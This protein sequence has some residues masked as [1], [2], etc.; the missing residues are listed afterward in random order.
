MGA[1]R[2]AARGSNR[3]ALGANGLWLM[4]I[5]LSPFADS[6]RDVP[7]FRATNPDF[8]TMAEPLRGDRR[9]HGLLHGADGDLPP[10]ERAVRDEAQPSRDPALDFTL[11]TKGTSGHSSASRPTS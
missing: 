7:H 1:A 2:P 8:G 11:R 4:P 5:R 6:A 9:H 3:R 10:S